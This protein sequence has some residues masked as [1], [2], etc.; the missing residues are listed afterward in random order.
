[1]TVLNNKMTNSQ[2]MANEAVKAVVN[3]GQLVLIDKVATSNP[4]YVN[5]YF[6]GNVKGNNGSSI[7]ATQ[8]MFLGWN[9]TFQ[10]RCIQNASTEIANN[11]EIGEGIDN[12][13]IQMFD[14][15]KP[16]FE[17]HTPRKDRDGNVLLNNGS[18]I[19]RVT[20]VN[21]KE[22]IE[23]EGHTTLEVTSRVTPD[24]EPIEDIKGANV[25][26]VLKKPEVTV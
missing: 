24:G 26:S 7:N 3:S 9:N 8:A 12:I 19:Y 2:L 1:M 20:V 22:T 13:G 15:I 5:L 25:D 23:S 4:D 10:Q 17:G 16:S 11:Y 14:S 21:A 18:P 6:F